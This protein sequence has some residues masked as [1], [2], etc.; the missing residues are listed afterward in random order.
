MEI[1][2]SGMAS[3]S[4]AVSNASHRIA[5]R[6]ATRRRTISTARWHDP[7]EN[8]PMF[9]AMKQDLRRTLDE[10]RRE[11][12]YKSERIITTP[13]GTSVDVE[14]PATP[15]TPAPRPPRAT[16]ATPTTP[17][18]AGTAEGV[19]GTGAAGIARGMHKPDESAAACREV[20]VMCANNYLGLAQHPAIREAAHQGLDEYGFCMAS[21]RFICGTQSIHKML[22]EKISGFLQTEDT[23]LYGS[24]FDANGGL[25]ETILGAEDAVIS[26]ELNHASIIDGIRLSKA[27]RYRYKNNDMADLEQQLKEAAAKGTRYRLIATDGVF[28]M[29]GYYAQLNRICDLAEKYDA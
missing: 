7:Q 16:P 22:E 11:G 13:Q 14:T 21:V 1:R 10:I 18:A 6:G 20:L 28:S 26:D 29:D 24:A 25:F 12:L 15:A 9:G 27:Q 2:I 4:I 3:A 5:F 23:I 19:S 17:P 8:P